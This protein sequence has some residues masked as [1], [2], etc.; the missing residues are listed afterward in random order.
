MI[1]E[2]TSPIILQTR[3]IAEWHPRILSPMS[4]VSQ[5]GSWSLGRRSHAKHHHSR[6]TE[7]WR[8]LL[9]SVSQRDIFAFNIGMCM[10]WVCSSAPRILLDKSCLRQILFYK[11][12][13]PAAYFPILFLIILECI[14]F[15]VAY[16]VYL[17]IAGKNDSEFNTKLSQRHDDTKCSR[18]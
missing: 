5:T 11:N 1:L 2:C 15:R 10:T 12:V 4:R 6:I 7:P 18:Q 3:N 14:W 17:F 8:L 16:T 13:W 9:S